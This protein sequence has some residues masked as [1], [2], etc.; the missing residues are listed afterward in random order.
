MLFNRAK[1][2]KPKPKAEFVYAWRGK[3][4]SDYPAVYVAI[5]RVE[6][7]QIAA[8]IRRRDR[9]RAIVFANIVRK[10]PPP[11]EQPYWAEVAA[12]WDEILSATNR[13]P[14]RLP[15]HFLEVGLQ[16]DGL[17]RSAFLSTA[18]CFD[19]DGHDANFG[20][21]CAAEVGGFL[22]WQLGMWSKVDFDGAALDSK[23]AR[24]WLLQC[25]FAK[26]KSLRVR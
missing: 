3:P 24:Q 12:I 11:T 23:P 17:E 22:S 10:N 21:Y 1:N 20:D 19:V 25:I 13:I 6:S 7:G 16:A 18:L 5:Q 9:A 8:A 2:A 4:R 26:W 14:P 15:T